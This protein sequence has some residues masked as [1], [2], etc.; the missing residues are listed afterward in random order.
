MKPTRV[1]TF[2][3]TTHL[4]HRSDT[5]IGVAKDSDASFGTRASAAKDAVGDK[6][7]QKSHEVYCSLHTFRF[8]D[9]TLTRGL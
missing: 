1:R 4:P 3:F 7:D 9:N 8:D 5:C 2:A 6:V